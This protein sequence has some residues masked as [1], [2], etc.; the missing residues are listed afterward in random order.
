MNL[1]QVIGGLILKLENAEEALVPPYR[2]RKA[3]AMPERIYNALVDHGR[4][5][6]WP[7]L[8]DL[9]DIQPEERQRAAHALLDLL[10]YKHVHR[11]GQRRHYQYWATKRA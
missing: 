11:D 10:E 3:G 4:K 8:V 1:A 9:C 6:T 5:I 2:P 7:E